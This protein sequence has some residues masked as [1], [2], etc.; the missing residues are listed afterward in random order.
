MIELMWWGLGIGLFVGA[1]LGVVMAG[2]AAGAKEGDRLADLVNWR[3]L[4][5]THHRDRIGPCPYCIAYGR[6]D[7]AETK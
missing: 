6:A 1:A 3:G 5:A 4:V 7:L 2:L